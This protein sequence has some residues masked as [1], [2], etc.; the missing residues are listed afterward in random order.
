MKVK[1][2]IAFI[3]ILSVLAASCASM[4]QYMPST[5]EETVIGTI[6][7]WHENAISLYPTNN[8]IS[9]LLK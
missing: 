6:Q 8:F 9:V 5:P 4:G 7:T 1:R 2:K 3:G